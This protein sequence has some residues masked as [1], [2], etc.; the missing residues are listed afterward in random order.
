MK[1]IVGLG[2]PGPQYKKTRH[3]VGIMVIE[4]LASE[5]RI[6]FSE[7]HEAFL[8][9]SGR[10]DHEPILIAKPRT[11]M[12]LSGAAVRHILE[13][14]GVDPSH[15]I[16]VHDD[17]DL[18]LGRI[19]IKTKGGHGGHKGILSILSTLQTD[20]FYR[21]RIGVGR[22]PR[23]L[24]AA[25]YVLR[26]FKSEEHFLLAGVLRQSVEALRC[27]VVVGTHKAME[28]YNRKVISDQ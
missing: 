28:R 6:A 4:T 14:T 19:Q 24:D 9:G 12:N 13:K 8:L 26:P 21:L 23:D 2:N 25:E 11:F 18:A 20:Q 7:K 3:N 16:V 17:I 22:P 27:M 10:V 15:L 1:L 5:C